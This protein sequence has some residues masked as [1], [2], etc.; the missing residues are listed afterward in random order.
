MKSSFYFWF[1]Q[2]KNT[3]KMKISILT[4]KKRNLI[5]SYTK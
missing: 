3:K 5:D 1:S 2:E 4:E